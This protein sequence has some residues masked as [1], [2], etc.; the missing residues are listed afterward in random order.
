MSSAG[1]PILVAEP[2]IFC[3]AKARS[4]PAAGRRT[5]V[6]FCGGGSSRGD[7]AGLPCPPGR[8]AGREMLHEATPHVLARRLL[9]HS[10][11]TTPPPLRPAGTA[12]APPPPP[13]LGVGRPPVV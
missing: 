2:T 13:V 6:G 1:I 10:P 12:G 8:T 4:E 11:I 9:T 5:I 3:G 7:A